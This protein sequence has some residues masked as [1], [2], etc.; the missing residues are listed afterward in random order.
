MS[1]GETRKTRK[2]S[3]TNEAMWMRGGLWLH[4]CVCPGHRRKLV[5]VQ[6]PER[7]Q[8]GTHARSHRARQCRARAKP[9]AGMDL[10]ISENTATNNMGFSCSSCWSI[11]G[12]DGCAHKVRLKKVDRMGQDPEPTAGL[13]ADRGAR[14]EG[15]SESKT[16]NECQI[17]QDAAGCEYEISTE[18]SDRS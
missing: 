2:Q 3:C 18:G 8:W 7:S 14:E 9:S 5:Q 17:R 1:C 15:D 12:M 10:Q 4:M 16:R 11:S 6:N 13:F